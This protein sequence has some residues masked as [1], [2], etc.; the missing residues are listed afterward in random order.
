VLHDSD[1]PAIWVNAADPA[2]SLILGTDKHEDGALYAFD[3]QGRVVTRVGGLK[4]PNNVDVEYGVALGGRLLDVAVVTERLADAIRAFRLPALEPIDGGGIPVFVGE[5]Q[6][7]PMGVALYKR[8][9]DGTVFAIV[10]RKSGPT[11][12]YLWQYRLEDDG[13][14]RVK[15][16]KVRA[17]GEF[18]GSGEI[19]AVAVDDELGYVYYS[20]E[21]TGVRKYH[22]DPDRPDAGRELALFATEG[23]AED[24]EGISIYASGDGAGYILVSD[25]QA[26]RF[27]VYPRQGSGGNP[28]DHPLLKTVRA[29][30]VGSDGS[31]ATSAALGERFPKGL[32]VAMSQGGVFHLYDWRELAG[33][34]L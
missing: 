33:P 18:S 21:S 22:A 2:R 1:D 23:F 19:E 34:D 14:G 25:Q 15:A 8:P 6:R 9:R 28:H 4:R 24:R 30:T 7:A 26:N 12:G 16:T 13:A 20:D 32:F 31:E 3:L 29:S 5:V 27:H 10:S 17:L 11:A